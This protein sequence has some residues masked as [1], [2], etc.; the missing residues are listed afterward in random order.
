VAG[1]VK[2]NK[3]KET[4]REEENGKRYDKHIKRPHRFIYTHA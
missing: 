3:N 1:E 4:E 2:A